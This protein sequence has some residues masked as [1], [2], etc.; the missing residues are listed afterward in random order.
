MFKE[1]FAHR[2]FIKG[3][4]MSFSQR[5]KNIIHDKGLSQSQAAKICKISQ[6][7]MNYMIN[8]DLQ[9]SKLAPR[10]AKEL[11]INPDWLIYGVGRPDK[12]A[13]SEVPLIHSVT[14]L[15]RFMQGKLAL[16][17]LD[18]TIVDQSL[19]DKAFAYLLKPKELLICSDKTQ[20]I[21]SQQYLVLRKDELIVSKESEK[22]AFPIIER[23]KRYKDF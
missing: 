17:A 10:I 6:Q 11:G 21:T 8:R 22:N 23:R 20:K 7:S 4:V 2:Y 3:V 16:N 18:F 14:M 19:G 12:R 1:E 15:K 5:L 9:S 13:L